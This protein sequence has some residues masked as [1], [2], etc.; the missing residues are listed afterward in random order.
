MLELAFQPDRRHRE[1]LYRQLA[2]YLLALIEAGQL[3][4]GQKLPAT[5]ELA[6]SL[7]VSRNT[8]NQAYEALQG[9]E[10]VTAHVGQG[11]FVAARAGA[12]GGLAE[13]PT[14][15]TARSFAWEGLFSSR[16]R[17]QRLPEAFRAWA[18]RPRM[19]FDFRGGRIDPALLPL[20]ELRRAFARA[21]DDQLLAHA[22]Q[23]DP[24]GH[25]PLREQ[26]A[27]SL[28]ARGVQCAAS[29]VLIVS[30]AQQGLDLVAR[31][32]LDPGDAV[33]VEQPGYFGARLAFEGADAR[34][35][36]VGVDAA[37]LRVGALA[38]VLR[39]RRVKLVYTTPAVQSPTGARMS[40][41][42]RHAL[43]ALAAEHQTAILEDDYDGELRLA[44]PPT[45][46]LKS[47]DPGGQVVYLGTF[48]KALFPTLRIGYL[49]GAPVLLDR[50][51]SARVSGQLGQGLIEQAALAELLAGG[52]LERHVR[53]LRRRHAA[54]LDATL[55]ALEAH[56]PGGTRF[57]RPAG[58]NTV[59]VGL[60][61]GVDAQV[62]EVRALEAGIA[63]TP[64]A[65]YDLEERADDHIA[66]C[67]A[68]QT[69]ERIAEGLAAL[70]ALVEGARR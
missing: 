36:G 20:R 27:R 31:A 57:E 17:A 9:A 66:L 49:V 30:G 45:P 14:D 1:P 62:L 44:G 56:F 64:G 24:F 28:V 33:V 23:V 8:V 40:E 22:N 60:P 41:A 43:L 69:P 59:W 46:A 58:G 32:L 12:F 42:R 63:Y 35:I 48:S 3:G 50:L 54:C 53:R 10:L 47:A 34:V 16:A 6:A 65:L 37:G 25:P 2:G 52:A 39:G 67:F 13:A 21:V 61:G 29:D 51:A 26:I 19:P 55:Q 18:R 7:G 4:P 68:D 5:R 15:E 38:R 11:T 70:G